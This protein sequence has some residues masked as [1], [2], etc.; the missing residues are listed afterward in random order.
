MQ[1]LSIQMATLQIPYYLSTI[2]PPSEKKIPSNVS[3]KYAGKT[4]TYFYQSITSAGNQ[5]AEA[6]LI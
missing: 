5:P 3:L 4:R 1:E 2:K 6:T